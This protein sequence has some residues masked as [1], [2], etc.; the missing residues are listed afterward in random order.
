VRE[1]LS[2]NAFERTKSQQCWRLL[3]GAAQLG[4]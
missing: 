4:R 2:N 3:L 1:M